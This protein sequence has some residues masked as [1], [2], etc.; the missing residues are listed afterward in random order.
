MQVTEPYGNQR[1][2]ID[3][4]RVVE[5]PEMP[6]S[7][8]IFVHGSMDRQAVFSSVIDRL[9]DIRCV[10]YDR[11]G[12]GSSVGVSGPYGVAEHVVD[13]EGVISAVGVPIGVGTSPVVLVG[14]SFGGVVALALAA[15]RPELVRAVAVYESPMSWEPWWSSSSGGA[16]AARTRHDPERAAEEFLVRFIGRRRW[17][18]LSETTKT[19]RRAEG[20]ALTEEL[21]D[22]RR[23]P[24]Y[25]FDDIRCSIISSVGSLAAPH[26]RRGAEMLAS[27]TTGPELVVLDGAG[28]GAPHDRPDDFASLVV[29]RCLDLVS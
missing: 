20:V 14:H 8:V 29:R 10:T 27:A 25:R 12:Y 2:V 7:T 26:I 17:D 28:H 13:L 4:V 3:S 24:A 1:S 21:S 19:R 9:P 15:R 11:R 5:S 16:M 23:G 6:Q 18:S 22:L